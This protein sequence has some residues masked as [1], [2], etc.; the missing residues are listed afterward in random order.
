MY[1]C[2]QFLYM[3]NI[4]YNSK[5]TLKKQCFTKNQKVA[6]TEINTYKYIIVTQ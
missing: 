5:C 2:A 6:F 4:I 3:N 1:E